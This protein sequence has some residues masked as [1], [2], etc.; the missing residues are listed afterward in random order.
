MGIVVQFVVVAF[1]KKIQH[2]QRWMCLL[3]NSHIIHEQTQNVL[4][5]FWDIHVLV[6][7]IDESIINLS[8]ILITCYKLKRFPCACNLFMYFVN[9][10]TT[11]LN[12]QL[13]FYFDTSG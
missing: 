9:R 12:Q 8:C 10:T 1:V 6:N 2:L 13:Y 4:L 11:L 3:K 7:S 5:G